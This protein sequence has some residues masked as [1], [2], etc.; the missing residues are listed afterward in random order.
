MK[1]YIEDPAICDDMGES[2]GQC[3]CGAKWYE[4]RIESLPDDEKESAEAVQKYRGVS[5]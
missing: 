4:H 1:N 2:K 3:C 5:D